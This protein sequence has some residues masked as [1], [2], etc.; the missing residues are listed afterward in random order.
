MSK[1]IL[2]GCLQL[3]LELETKDNL[4]KMAILYTFSKLVYVVYKSFSNMIFSSYYYC[5]IFT[6]YY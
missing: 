2:G 4:I 1:L 6:G 5:Y 3:K